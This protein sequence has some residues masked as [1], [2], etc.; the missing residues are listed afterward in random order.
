M[1]LTQA[2]LTCGE[3]LA[4]RLELY[5]LFREASECC[6]TGTRAGSKRGWLAGSG[7]ARQIRAA[8]RTIAAANGKTR[9][10]VMAPQKAPMP[11][12]SAATVARAEPRPRVSV[13]IAA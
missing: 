10:L 1:C 12:I 11:P 8:S 13:A 7:A 6:Y 2:L 9:T 5:W 4:P 3:L